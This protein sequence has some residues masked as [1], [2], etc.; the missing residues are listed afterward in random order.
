MHKST[1]RV[2]K[3]SVCLAGMALATNVMAETAKTKA[4]QEVRLR[5]S[6]TCESGAKPPLYNIVK[7]PEHGTIVF[8]DVKPGNRA[9]SRSGGNASAARAAFYKP[10]SS[11]RGTDTVTLEWQAS[12]GRPAHRGSRV[13]P[14]TISVE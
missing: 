1:S 14:Y 7:Q 8:R 10:N 12:S 5:V 2:L 11:F 9:C 6:Y 3:I 4:G 13:Y